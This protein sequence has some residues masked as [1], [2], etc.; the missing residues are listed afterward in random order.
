MQHARSKSCCLLQWTSKFTATLLKRFWETLNRL[1][2]HG[3]PRPAPAPSSSSSYFSSAAESIGTPTA[4]LLRVSA[5]RP[6]A[7]FTISKFKEIFSCLNHESVF[8]EAAGR[9]CRA[10]LTPDQHRSLTVASF[11]TSL[12]L[13]ENPPLLTWHAWELKWVGIQ[14][15]FTDFA[16]TA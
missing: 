3:A 8:Q 9:V 10:H 15:N 16:E 6:V 4:L 2:L 11:L 14:S 13:S 12:R 7:S 1:R 5:N